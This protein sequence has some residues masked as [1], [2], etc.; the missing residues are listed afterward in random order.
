MSNAECRIPNVEC[1]IPT[2][3]VPGHSSFVI[4]ALLAL[5]LALPSAGWADW[6][7]H[8]GNPQRTGSLDDQPGPATPAVLWAY[9][10][11][12]HFVASVVPQAQSLYI[13]GLGAYNM[14][15][16]HCVAAEAD[17]RS[18][19]LWSKMSV[20]PSERSMANAAQRL[21]THLLN[22]RNAAAWPRSAKSVTRAL[23]AR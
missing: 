13:A 6:L 17:T 1:R 8:R 3:S 18:R 11:Q 12:Q 5:L 16:L 7:T 2:R 20:D 23:R 14:G 21:P 9:K 19:V 22:R 4:Q 15:V 10:A